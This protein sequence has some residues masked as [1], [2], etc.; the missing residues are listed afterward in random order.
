MYFSELFFLTK[1]Q[2][3]GRKIIY[4]REGETTRKDNCR[5]S[6]PKIGDQ[7]LTLRRSSP[8]N[9]HVLRVP[10]GPVMEK[11]CSSDGSL[12]LEFIQKKLHLEVCTNQ[13]KYNQHIQYAP[14]VLASSVFLQILISE[15][16]FF[17]N[18]FKFR[19]VMVRQQHIN[20]RN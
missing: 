20:S 10:R 7:L 5:A 19:S 18:S 12:L 11:Q 1:H 15:S 4:T 14:S 16:N 2:F 9:S 8:D 17:P 13:S 3:T 6:H